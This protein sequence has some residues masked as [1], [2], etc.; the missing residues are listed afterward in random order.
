MRLFVISA[1]MIVVSFAL[2]AS[3]LLYG[4]YCLTPLTKDQ[5]ALVNAY[6]QIPREARDRFSP[7]SAEEINQALEYRK[8]IS[9]Y[10]ALPENYR[11]SLDKTTNLR[12]KTIGVV[13][14]GK[15]ATVVLKS[16]IQEGA[17]ISPDAKKADI[18]VYETVDCNIMYGKRLWISYGGCEYV[19]T[20]PWTSDE[21]SEIKSFVHG[22]ASDVASTNLSRIAAI[23]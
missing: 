3:T 7:C 16:L 13:Y 10:N 17:S 18:K 2:L 14:S 21:S 8:A 22:F 6:R 23:K 9:A 11:L 15:R 4:K 19:Y 20:E 1:T 5:A 12:G